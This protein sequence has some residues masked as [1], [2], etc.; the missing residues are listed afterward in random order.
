MIESGP[1]ANFWRVP[2]DNDEGGGDKSY[3]SLW[4]NAGLDTLEQISADIKTVRITAHSYKVLLSK[5]LKADYGQMTVNSVYTIFSTG[6]IHVRNTFIP[7]GEWP[8]LPKVGVQFQMPQSF[9]KAQWYGNG[10]HETY[11]D[12]KT[13]G[14]IGLYSG[15]VSGQHFPYINPQ[16]NGNK[17]DVR[18]ASITNTDGLGLLII[19]DSVFNFSSH[20]YTDKALLAAKQRGSTLSRG[21][22]TLV[23]IDYRLM[24]LGGDD[25]W[26]PRVHAEYLIPT[27]TYSYSF[28]L[29]G[30]DRSSNLDQIIHVELPVI[31][32]KAGEN[33]TPES[34]DELQQEEVVP[35]TSKKIVRPK[36]T[37]HYSKKVSPQKK[38]T[39]KKVVKKATPAKKKKRRR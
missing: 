9:I 6:D 23:N 39:K 30:I 10:P 18:W 32:E 17:T 37:K 8:F 34:G 2:T 29:K 33:F 4:R 25:S 1:Y 22:T 36:T 7:E 35:A 27:R 28:R 21:K 19:S 31:S 20:D 5:T 14:R 24:G 15:T 3:A 11:P 12:R 13:S 16:E 26:S 38:S